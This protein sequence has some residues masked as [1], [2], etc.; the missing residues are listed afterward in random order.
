MYNRKVKKEISMSVV[1]SGKELIITFENIS[2]WKFINSWKGLPFRN[3]R[4][5]F[6]KFVYIFLPFYWKYMIFKIKVIWNAK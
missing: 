2:P 6:T 3:N 5:L 1:D 4:N